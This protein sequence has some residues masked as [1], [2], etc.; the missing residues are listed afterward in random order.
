MTYQL[1]NMQGSIENAGREN[2]GP[3][4]S[5]GNSGMKMQEMRTECMK[6]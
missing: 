2:D 5:R 3:S 6:Q 1:E 4:K